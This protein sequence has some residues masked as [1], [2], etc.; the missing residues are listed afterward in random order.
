ME[1]PIPISPF[2][3]TTY[4]KNYIMV[5]AASPGINSDPNCNSVKDTS[6][7]FYMM[8]L[9]ER[10]FSSETYFR[11][12]RSMMSLSDV[13]ANGDVVSIFSFV[14]GNSCFFFL[15]YGLPLYNTHPAYP[16]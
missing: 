15:W 14:F 11:S 13:M 5:D 3:Q 1:L 4:N 16:D 10:D 9:P 8:Y 2:L 12:L 6:L 7:Y